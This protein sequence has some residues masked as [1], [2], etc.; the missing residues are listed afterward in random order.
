MEE[1][2]YHRIVAFGPL[3]EQ[4]MQLLKKGAPV[5]VTGRLAYREYN[6]LVRFLIKR[7][8][9]KEGGPTDTSRDHELTDWD[10]VDRLGREMA[11]A[12]HAR[13]PA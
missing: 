11:S 4:C 6:F 7:I 9:K 13:V 10:E 5:F 1:T 12:I 2:A 3:A 8:A